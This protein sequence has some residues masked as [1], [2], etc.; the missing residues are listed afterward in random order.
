V[1]K[2]QR[3][4]LQRHMPPDWVGFPMTHEPMATGGAGLRRCMADSHVKRFAMPTQPAPHVPHGVWRWEYNAS[5]GQT[6]I[7]APAACSAPV[8]GKNHHTSPSPSYEFYEFYEFLYPYLPLF[9]IHSYVC[10][11]LPFSRVWTPTN[12]LNS[13]NSYRP[14][15][16]QHCAVIGARLY[17]SNSINHLT[18]YAG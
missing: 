15:S 1:D 8:E 2:P 18:G 4:A 14:D 12:S 3:Y 17:K 6:T 7:S 16:P 5:Q 11:L 13:L 9:V 10:T